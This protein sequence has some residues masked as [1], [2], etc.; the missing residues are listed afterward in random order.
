ME[1]EYLL[2]IVDLEYILIKVVVDWKPLFYLMEIEDVGY[3]PLVE[4]N[5][6]IALEIGILDHPSYSGIAMDVDVAS[7]VMAGVFYE[8]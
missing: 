4:S 7:V 6:S 5:S 3:G 2:R 1:G 8:V